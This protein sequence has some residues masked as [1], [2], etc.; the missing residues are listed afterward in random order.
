[1][2]RKTL[3]QKLKS[4]LRLEK[5][6]RE[7]EHAQAG[8]TINFEL[9]AMQSVA[10]GHGIM[11]GLLHAKQVLGEYS[12]HYKALE[13]VAQERIAQCFMQLVQMGIPHEVA[14]QRINQG[15]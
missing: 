8:T 10:M 2:P 9:Q 4:Q 15:H 6:A 11:A 5:K 1:M 3:K 14:Q 13:P 12:E 7:I